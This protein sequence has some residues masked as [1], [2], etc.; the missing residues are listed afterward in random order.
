MSVSGS[1]SE[2][3][4]NTPSGDI[5]VDN[6]PVFRRVIQAVCDLAHRPL[7]DLRILDLA[8]AHGAYSIELAARGARVLGIEGREAWLEQA[9]GHKR[10]LSLSNV[11]FVKDDVRNLSKEKYG[12][13]DIVLCLGILYHLDAPDVFDFLN[14]VADVCRDFAIIETHFA[15]TPAVSREWRDKRYSGES[16]PE[17]AAGT[18]PEDKLKDLGAS[19]DNEE[20]FYL[21][22]ASLCNI[23][24]HTGFTSVYDCR[25]PIANLYVGEGREFQMWGSRVT[26]AA[27]KGQAVSLTLHSEATAES[28]ADWPE[29]LDDFLFERSL[30]QAWSDMGERSSLSR[31]RRG[32]RRLLGT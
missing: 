25:N 24:R 10:D 27:I 13:F 26:L 8:C 31:V 9:R 22:Q 7:H 32:I 29:K 3:V 30:A 12:E 1:L 16:H 6:T 5:R 11:E 18:T 19:L 28:E 21:T 14:S 20:A 23:L 4:V 15:G 2:V 17:H